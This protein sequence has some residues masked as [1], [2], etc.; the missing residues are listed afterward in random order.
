MKKSILFFFLLLILSTACKQNKQKNNQT[1]AKSSKIS[2]SYRLH[3]NFWKTDTQIIQ[4]I[5]YFQ[6]H[7]KAVNKLALFDITMPYRPLRPLSEIRKTCQIMEKRIQQLKKAG[8]PR[9]GVN[10]LS[11]IGFRNPE[12]VAAAGFQQAVPAG[13][14]KPGLMSQACVNDSA[15]IEYT[16]EYY[17]INARM[18]PDFI[19]I[20]DDY[21]N[22]T[23]ACFCSTCLNK[24]GFKGK[25]E[26]L[27]AQLDQPENTDLRMKWTHFQEQSMNDFSK[28]IK[29]AVNEIN[30]DIDI[31]VMTIGYDHALY[32]GYNFKQWM[33]TLNAKM[34]RPGHGFYHDD[35]PR[36]VLKKIMSVS[37]QVR[38]CPPS[39]TDIQYELENWPYVT[40]QKSVKTFVNE[41]TLAHV[42]G[43]TGVACNIFYERGN[44][45]YKEYDP[46][47]NAVAKNRKLWE[48]INH[49]NKLPLTGFYPLDSR[50]IHAKRNVDETSWFDD[51]NAYDIQKA[52][53]FSEAGIPLT[54]SPQQAKVYL[55]TGKTA[56][57][58]SKEELKEMLSKSVWLDTEALGVLWNKG[59][60]HLTGVKRS[61]NWFFG[62]E[63]FT[64]HSFNGKYTGDGRRAQGWAGSHYLEI[65][66]PD[67]EVL[68]DFYTMQQIKKGP[69]F[70]IFE[71]KL[72]GKVAVSSYSPWRYNGRN[73]KH[74]QLTQVADWLSNKQMPL[75]IEE[76]VRLVPYVRMSKEKNKFMI[77]LFNTSFDEI[78]NLPL[79]IRANPE[80]LYIIN[81]L[82]QKENLNFITKDREINLE[83]T[84]IQPWSVIILIGE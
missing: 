42:A 15:F 40:T 43:C 14:I 64:E 67:V 72:G 66:N 8:I 57:A 33:K 68:S 55:F 22:V 38:D 71:N 47:L 58:Y 45:H 51:D 28:V 39:V 78:R 41:I 69:C 53:P 12:G 82:H 18:N 81:E 76:N 70:T 34:C 26:E 44:V 2:L 29:K 79:T 65:K 1:Q 13:G 74:H 48:I 10:V 77:A 84:S 37:R 17:R 62:V 56:E 59:L 32:G 35:Q 31:G 54:T 3:P 21:R 25:K 50:Y 49:Y 61:E 52:V 75:I 19:W 83:I 63:Y 11:T 6:Q 7:P 4:T 27:I 46:F 80:E 30:P 5:E 20:D 16:K 24:F 60:G 73:G 23:N 9:V 36:A